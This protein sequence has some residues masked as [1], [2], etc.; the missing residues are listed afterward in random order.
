MDWIGELQALGATGCAMVLGGVVGYERELK[1]R[2]AGFRTHMLVAGAAALLM[3][4]SQLAMSNPPPHDPSVRIQTTTG[5]LGVS[6]P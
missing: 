5:V 4:I 3:G 1:N 6:S 2:P